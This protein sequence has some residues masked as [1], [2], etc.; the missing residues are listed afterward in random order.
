MEPR[1][2]Q[3][4]LAAIIAQALTD[5][6]APPLKQLNNDKSISLL[7][8]DTSTALNFLFDKGSMIELYLELLDMDVGEFRRNLLEHMYHPKKMGEITETQLRNM[9]INYHSLQ[10]IRKTHL[11]KV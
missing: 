9:R 10:K 3:K 4:L 8:R 1:G 2:E 11:E 5:A 6:A 7:S